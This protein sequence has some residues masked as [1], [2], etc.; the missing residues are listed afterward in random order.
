MNSLNPLTLSLQGTHLIEASAGTGKTYTIAALYVRLILGHKIE[1]PLMPQSILVVTFT[2]AATEELRDR[3]RTRLSESAQYFR[4]QIQSEDKFLI[5]LRNDYDEKK[6]NW[7]A[8]NLEVAANYMDEAAV[9]TIHSWCNR[10]LQQHAFDSGSPFKQDVNT[11]DAEL[12]NNVICDYWRVHFYSLDKNQCEFVVKKLATSPDD[13]SGKIRGLLS[14][15]E[16]LKLNDFQVEFADIFAEWI[17]WKNENLELEKIAKASWKNDFETINNLL[18]QANSEQWLNGVRYN[19]NTF[20][21]KLTEINNWAI[22]N[23]SCDLK[24]IAK[25]G[26]GNLTNGLVKAHQNKAEQFYFLAFQAIDD[27]VNHGHIEQADNIVIQIKLHAIKWIRNRYAQEKKKLSRVTFD[28]MLSN[29]DNSLQ[30]EKSRLGEVIRNQYPVALIDEFQDTDPIQY[31]IFSTIYQNQSSSCFL[32]GDPKQAIY[33]FRGAD[34]YTYLKAHRATQNHHTLDTNFRS[35]KSLVEAINKLF[36]HVESAFRFGNQ[37]PFVSVEANGRKDNWCINNK[38][39]PA[40]TFL[41]WQEDKIPM[42]FYR[43]QMAK[44]TA[45]EIVKLLSDKT[46][47]FQSE[48]GFKKLELEDIAI[49]V[50]NRNEAK[51][52]R[53][54]LNRRNLKSVYLSEQDSIYDTDEANDV[55]I[56]LEA[57]ANPRD[58]RKVRAAVSTGTLD[59]SKEELYLFTSDEVQWET[60][61]DRFQTYQ[62]RWQESGILPTLRLLIHDYGLHLSRNDENESERKLTNV[63]HLAEL[64]QQHSSKIEGEEALIHHFAQLLESKNHRSAKDNIVRLESDSN[65]IKIITIHK[66]KGLEY[67]LVFLPFVSGIKDITRKE[68][69]FKFHDEKENLCIDLDKTQEGQNQHIEELLQEDLRIL[70]VAVTRAKYA[71]WLGIASTNRLAQSAIG[72]LIGGSISNLETVKGK[73]KCNSIEIVTLPEPTN[74]KFTSQSENDL[75]NSVREST[76]DTRENWWAASYSALKLD[77]KK[78]RGDEIAEIETAQDNNDDDTEFS[79]EASNNSDVYALPKGAKPGVLIHTLFEKCGDYGFAS[80]HKNQDWRTETI[81][82]IFSDNLWNNEKRIVIDNALPTW[83][84]MPLVENAR[85]IDLAKSNYKSELE[86]LIGADFVDVE[87]LDSLITKATFNNEKRPALEKNQLNGFLKG[88]IDLVFCHENKYYILDYKFNHLGNSTENYSDAKMKETMLE[89][90]YDLQYSLYLLTLHRL[91]KIRLGDSYDY[92]THIGGAIY[93]FLR[94]NA[95][96]SN[97]PS[98][99]FIEQLDALFLGENHG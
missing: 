39:A 32:I 26:L 30:S 34:I 85:F 21:D 77:Y 3:I 62:I 64:L 11:D 16:A 70:Y 22:K 6:W 5:E 44:V 67:P 83:L 31:R 81:K 71:C 35:T 49:L 23:Q 80:A 54:E 72:H 52:I 17:E 40:L 75:N 96:I 53:R 29:L 63:L 19:R 99:E 78:Q 24:E 91:L 90:R 57:M 42:E 20:H 9:F 47:G 7:C 86:F 38:I 36:T 92:D 15:T 10:M 60:H 4:E 56:W 76:V 14:E 73:C 79:V 98:R 55:L 95:K 27:F 93:I 1:I 59:F 61:L 41:T 48:T 51:I 58:E 50:R 88:F 87:K 2:D 13:F 94:A 43:E 97:K 68:H 46:A 25:F 12:L 82:N 69:F 66:S 33:S 74:D 65:L 18:N 84:E 89:K 45:S 37:L 28:D 8:K